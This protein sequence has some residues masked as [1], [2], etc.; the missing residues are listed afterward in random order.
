MIY[1][2][3]TTIQYVICKLSGKPT[4]IGE[5]LHLH[6]FLLDGALQHSSVV[7][8][9]HLAVQRRAPRLRAGVLHQD[10]QL[11]IGAHLGPLAVHLHVHG[12]V[13]RHGLGVGVWL[14]AIATSRLHGDAFLV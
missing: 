8:D 10:A 9:G 12:H 11:G 13:L 6:V 2:S 7:H 3:N 14:A 4:F 1:L 5:K